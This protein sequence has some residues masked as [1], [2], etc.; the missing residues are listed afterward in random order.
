MFCVLH[1]GDHNLHCGVA[2]FPGEDSY[3]KLAK[4][5]RDSFTRSYLPETI[6]L[7]DQGF[8]GQTYS[9]KHLFRDEQRKVLVEVI[10]STVQDAESAFRQLYELQSP[11]LR[12][13]GDCHV[14]IPK[15]MKATAEVALNGL[16]HDA[17]EA[18]ELNIPQIQSLLEELRV[19]GVPLDT[20]D[21][22]MTL[23]R[24]LERACQRFFDN[25]RDLEILREVR[26][27]VEAAKTVPLPLLLWSVQNRAHE[28]L[29]KIYRE[30]EEQGQKEWLAEFTQLSD[31]LC[32]RILS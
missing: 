3:R 4:A 25:P 15:E 9:L 29:Q 23:R 26:E 6:H 22:E 20:E 28:V 24:N 7:I 2:T 1:L 31:L 27:F 5:T 21:L 16:L 17:L 32:L 10:D 11:V 13:M 18:P 8:K 14:P 12:F 19:A 30:M